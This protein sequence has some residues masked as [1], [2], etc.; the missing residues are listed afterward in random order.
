[1]FPCSNGFFS[2]DNVVSFVKDEIPNGSSPVKL[3]RPSLRLVR[4]RKLDILLGTGPV[5][6]LASRFKYFIRVKAVIN[7]IPPWNRLP[8]KCSCVIL[9]NLVS[10]CGTSPAKLFTRKRKLPKRLSLEIPFGSFPVKLLYPNSR[11]WSWW[12]V[13]SVSVARVFL[14]SA[15]LYISVGHK[16][17]KRTSPTIMFIHLNVCP[18]FW[19]SFHSKNGSSC[20]RQ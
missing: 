18:I 4:Y 9:V 14:V 20:G 19:Q 17:Y 3:F 2:T 7:A 13:R 11:V 1:M 12:I 15:V 5:K 16:F 8:P 6:A 10:F